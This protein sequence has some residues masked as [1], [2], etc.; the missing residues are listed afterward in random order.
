MA[1]LKPGTR[2]HLSPAELN[3]YVEQQVPTVTDGVRNPRIE[4]LGPEMARGSALIDFAK[5]RS[6]Q[7]HPPGW[8][9][10]RLLEGERPVTVTARIRSAG[11]TATVDVQSVDIS[12][13]QIDGRTLDFLID[14]F[15]LPLYPTAAV[16]RP[17]ELGYHIEKLDV[18]P[19]GVGVV[20][21]N[22]QAQ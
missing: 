14:H 18:Q 21:G 20:I 3:A 22:Y 1:R 10:S 19:G 2:V 11:G 5:V 8:L 7:G 16:N 4:L 6:S 9:M 12:G 17:F 13:V 15:L